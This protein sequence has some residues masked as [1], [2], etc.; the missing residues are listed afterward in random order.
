MYEVYLKWRTGVWTYHGSYAI[1]ANAFTR[2]NTIL[3]YYDNTTIF[4]VRTIK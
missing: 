3:N 1:Y 2:G 4:E